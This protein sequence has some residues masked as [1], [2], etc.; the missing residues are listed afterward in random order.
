MEE[1]L[2]WIVIS[3]AAELAVAWRGRPPAGR[4]RNELPWN[5]F[6][7]P[8]RVVHKIA[9]KDTRSM[10]PNR[11]PRKPGNPAPDWCHRPA[12]PKLRKRSRGGSRER[13]PHLGEPIRGKRVL[14]RIVVDRPGD[15]DHEVA[16]LVFEE[17]EALAA[18]RTL[19]H[20]CPI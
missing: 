9:H 3:V 17:Q 13:Q 20:D 2:P 5:P 12:S 7:A 14:V 11:R 4:R 10:S 18:K 6:P 15:E 1:R 8:L 19:D 16:P